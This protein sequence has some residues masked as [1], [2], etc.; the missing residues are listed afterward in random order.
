MKGLKV[1]YPLTVAKAA[2]HT[3][4]K[5][6]K[7]AENAAEH[8]RSRKAEQKLGGVSAISSNDDKRRAKAIP[9][10]IGW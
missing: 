1:Q 6:E 3:P 9:N 10:R 2:Q 4:H 5:Q 8:N 7:R